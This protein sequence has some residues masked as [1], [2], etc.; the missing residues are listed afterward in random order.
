MKNMYF[1]LLLAEICL[2]KHDLCSHLIIMAMV[3]SLY[4]FIGYFE[5]E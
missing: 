2:Q 5:L 1:K 3:G 4:H